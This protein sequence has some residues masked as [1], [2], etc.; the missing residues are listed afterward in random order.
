[1]VYPHVRDKETGQLRRASWDEAYAA[2]TAA[3]QKA[4]AERG[5]SSVL[6]LIHAGHGTGLLA[7]SLPL[8]LWTALGATQARNTLCVS[9][10]R[11]AIAL[12]YGT[13]GHSAQPEA[14]SGAP[15]VVMWGLNAA[16]SA[17]DL[18]ALATAHPTATRIVVID[19]RAT[20]TTTAAE[21][22]LWLRPRPGADAAVAYAV[23]ARLIRMAAVDEAFLAQH[24]I[25]Y[26]AFRDRCLAPDVESAVADSGV[27]A[28][29]LDELASLYATRRPSVTM[30]G[31]GLQRSDAGAEA[32]RVIS[33]IPTLLGMHRGFFFGNSYDIDSNYL[34]Q[35]AEDVTSPS[36]SQSRLGPLLAQGAFS[37]VFVSGMNPAVVLPDSA[38]VRAGLGRDDCFLVVHTTHLNDTCTFANIVLPACASH[39]VEDVEVLQASNKLHLHR[40]APVVGECISEVELMHGLAE[41]LGLTRS[42]PR[43]CE[44]QLDALRVALRG[45]CE[46]IPPGEEVDRLLRGEEL[47]LR[48]FPPDLYRTP[49]GKIEFVSSVAESLGLSPL[50]L[51]AASTS[52][53][54]SHSHSSSSRGS[55]K[56]SRPGFLLINS[57]DPTHVETVPRTVHVCKADALKLRVDT[58]SIVVLE[59]SRGEVHLR[60]LVTESVP[61]GV[62]WT[63]R[64]AMG[65][66]VQPLN[67]LT[68][69]ESLAYGEA[70]AFNQTH[71]NIRPLDSCTT[72][73]NSTATT[74]QHQK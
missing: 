19:P 42:F 29:Q 28:E 44:S 71:I 58:G 55:D 40:P 65:L 18:W 52:S 38:A 13:T 54:S 68:G 39:E 59:N 72:D 46:G 33:L 4:R 17:P 6:A 32:V 16:V 5:A 36:V 53:S 62:V 25:G 1:V 35:P 12:H 57:A 20:P 74:K 30:I 37:F 26:A 31:V 63:A 21:G 34:E 56:S 73:D 3:L 70:A 27:S 48:P 47:R 50:P 51:L 64:E 66:N 2:A 49:S 69:S 9:G 15:L 22:T 43:L 7:S 60:V 8:R 61:E 14:A 23:A 45:A 67:V 11:A 41:R 24:T 10:G